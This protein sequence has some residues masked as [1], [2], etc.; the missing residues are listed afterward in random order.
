MLFLALGVLAGQGQ[1]FP[2]ELVSTMASSNRIRRGLL[3]ALTGLSGSSHGMS[4]AVGNMLSN[5]NAM[6]NSNG[7]NSGNANLGNLLASSSNKEPENLL[8][9][10]MQNKPKPYAFNDVEMTAIQAMIS[11]RDI[12]GDLLHRVGINIP[13]LAS[14]ITRSETDRKHPVTSLLTDSSSSP[15]SLAS[16]LSSTKSSNAA[17]L[18]RGLAISLPLLIPMAT[19]IRRMSSDSAAITPLNQLNLQQLQPLNFI[20][21]PYYNQALHRRRGKRS[22]NSLALPA[23]STQQFQ[24][25][26]L[27]A[28]Q[29]IRALEKLGKTYRST[30]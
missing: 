6:G 1:S 9:Q 29:I 7:A 17:L 25:H 11:L 19:Q 12:L 27:A 20:P 22:L 23:V 18:L 30:K 3:S 24:E 5:S 21:D 15:G 16:A 14:L 2:N 26:L 4:S 8:A 10:A 13:S 28:E